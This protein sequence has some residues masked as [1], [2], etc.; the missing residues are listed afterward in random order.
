M[1]INPILAFKAANFNSVNHTRPMRLNSPSFGMAQVSSD[2]LN[3]TKLSEYFTPKGTF[4]RIK[5][6]GALAG[7]IKEI[8][9]DKEVTDS[10]KTRMLLAKDSHGNTALHL[11]QDLEETKA[12]IEGAPNNDTRV[13]MLLAKNSG[14]NRAP[15]LTGEE[16]A[17]RYMVETALNLA[18]KTPDVSRKESIKLLEAYLDY[19]KHSIFNMQDLNQPFNNALTALQFEEAQEKNLHG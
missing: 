5:I 3:C 9:N 19:T 11:A 4:E 12:L 8:L 18:T 6:M 13:K 10:L 2:F 17:K 14:N 1:F 15:E 7:E 16:K